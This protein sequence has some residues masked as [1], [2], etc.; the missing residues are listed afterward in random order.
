MESSTWSS[1]VS[2][3]FINAQV[4]CLTGNGLDLGELE[5]LSGSL[6]VEVGDTNVLDEALVDELFDQLSLKVWQTLAYL[7]HL[8]PGGRDVLTEVEVEELLARLA[9]DGVLLSGE[10]TL[11][12]VN[13]KVDLI[14]Q[15]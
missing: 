14:G 10:N 2:G 11:W 7:L 3:Y 12:G 6:N 9:L 4:F 5:E 15:T 8:G 13:L 1:F